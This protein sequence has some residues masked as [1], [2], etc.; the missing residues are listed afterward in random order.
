MGWFRAELP[1]ATAEG[2]ARVALKLVGAGGR[3]AARLEARGV[4]GDLLV[5]AGAAEDHRAA[6]DAGDEDGEVAAQYREDQHHC[7][8]AFHIG[9]RSRRHGC[10]LTRG[11]LKPPSSA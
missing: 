2:R 7:R 8:P 5:S 1:P 4:P 6:D 10:F 11:V 3:D 9:D